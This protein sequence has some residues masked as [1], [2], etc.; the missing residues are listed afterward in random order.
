MEPL[1]GTA[2]CGTSLACLR[3]HPVAV[4][5]DRPDTI[6]SVLIR[7]Q[8]QA[9][10]MQS[11][12][13]M[14]CRATG[15]MAL[16]CWRR[17]HPNCNCATPLPPPALPHGSRYSGLLHTFAIKS[18]DWTEQPRQPCLLETSEATDA[19][20]S[21]NGSFRSILWNHCENESCFIPKAFCTD[22]SKPLCP[23]CNQPT[24]YRALSNST[25]F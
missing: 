21:L 19:A 15:Q 9:Q 24:S 18:L 7:K 4:M 12:L 8:M 2:L 3:V 1:W 17:V 16:T 10:V 25:E 6:L 14:I 13:V 23:H 5:N 22:Y 20:T 11:V